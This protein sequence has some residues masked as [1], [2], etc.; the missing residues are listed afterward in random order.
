LPDALTVAGSAG[1]VA[2]A[3][4]ALLWSSYIQRQVLEDMALGAA[5]G[6][7]CACCATFLAYLLLRAFG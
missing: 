2:G 7:V 4:G 5:I 3:I 1:S 6:A